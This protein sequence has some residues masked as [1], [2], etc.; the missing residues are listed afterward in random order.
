MRA[1]HS[2]QAGCGVSNAK[3]PIT[4]N[5]NETFPRSA[6]FNLSLPWLIKGQQMNTKNR[7]LSNF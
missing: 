1:N 7:K 3:Q 4:I 6:D 5:Q 2:G